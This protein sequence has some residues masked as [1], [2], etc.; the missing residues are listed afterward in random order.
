MCLC[1]KKLIIFFA[2]QLM[3]EIR[4][5]VGLRCRISGGN[6]VISTKDRSCSSCRFK[7]CL[8]IGMEAKNIWVSFKYYLVGTSKEM[9]SK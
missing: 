1:K 9:V 8:A 2:A 6:C 7:K 4:I 5:S 3:I